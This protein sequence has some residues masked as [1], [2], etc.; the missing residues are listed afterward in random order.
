MVSH[1]SAAISESFSFRSNLNSSST[2]TAPQS[3]LKFEVRQLQALNDVFAGRTCR[4]L[5]Q[6]PGQTWART[7]DDVADDVDGATTSIADN[8]EI[9]LLIN[10]QQ[11]YERLDRN[12]S[13]D[14]DIGPPINSLER[15]QSSGLGLRH[16]CDNR[17][18]DAAAFVQDPSIFDSIFHSLSRR[19]RP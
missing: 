9:A 10:S 19:V 1:A 17:V 11:W 16:I 14:V 6:F 18:A 13:T 2:K 15:G 12:C 5:P 7:F 4:L 8:K 3:A